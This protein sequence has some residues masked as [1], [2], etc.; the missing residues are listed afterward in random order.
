MHQIPTLDDVRRARDVI[1]PYLAVTPLVRSPRLS[2][3]LECGV[4]LKL[5]TLQPIGAFKIRGGI[6]LMANLPAEERARGVITASTGNHGQ[7]IAYAARAF[8]VPCTIGAPEG[9]NPLK[10]AAM[11]ELGATVVLTGKDFDAAREWVEAEA[12]AKGLRY[13]HSANEPLLIAG[14][15]TVSLEVMEALPSVEAII[16]PVGGGSGVSGHCLVAKAIKPGVQVIG[17]Q[18]E[19]APAAYRSWRERRLVE[20]PSADTAAEGMATRVAFELTMRVLWDGLDDFVL[21]S[22]RELRQAVVAM[23]EHGRVLAEHAGAAPLAAALKLR[24]RLRGRTVVLI[25]SG[26]NIT[27]EQLRAILAG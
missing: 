24:D 11:R 19:R 22:E 10:V 23:L 1:A 17:V 13:I 4:Y 26:G 15:G 14:V 9:S 18:A 5:E 8:G 7:S 2:R 27:M 20:E 25:V 6:N 16:V 3:M 21:V 12:R